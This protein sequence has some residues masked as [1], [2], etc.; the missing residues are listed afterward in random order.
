MESKSS[1]ASSRCSNISRA[2]LTRSLCETKIR[3]EIQQTEAFFFLV[4]IFER[5]LRD[6]DLKRLQSV[7]SVREYSPRFRG[8][9]KSL[10]PLVQKRELHS[11]TAWKFSPKTPRLNRAWPTNDAMPR[12]AMIPPP[13]PWPAE[14]PGKKARTTGIELRR[15]GDIRHPPRSGG[16]YGRSR[17]QR[18]LFFSAAPIHLD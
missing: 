1:A 11:S 4:R 10:T 3:L 17:E 12:I 14:D 13:R 8:H 7:V 5:F 6:S 2:L 18:A 15:R 9:A 16:L